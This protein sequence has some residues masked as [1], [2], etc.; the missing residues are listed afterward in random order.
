MAL[1]ATPADALHEIV[2]ERT[3]RSKTFALPDGKKLIHAR[4]GRI[5]YQDDDGKLKDIDTTVGLDE[6]AGEMVADKLPYKFRL[7]RKG[8]GFTYQSRAGGKVAIE[9]EA[10]GGQ[11]FD[12]K[13]F[14]EA[15]RRGNR[16]TFSDVAADL[17]IVVAIDPTGVRT[18]RVL[19][20]VNAPKTWRWRIEGDDEGKAKLRPRINGFDGE[21]RRCAGLTVEDTGDLRAESWDGT[22]VVRLDPS[23]RIPSLSEDVSYPVTI[24]PDVT[25]TI[26]DTTQDGYEYG[27]VFWLYGSSRIGATGGGSQL[28]PGWRFTSVA[29]DQGQAISEAILTVDV[30]VNLGYGGPGTIYG[31]DTDDAAAWSPFALTVSPTSIAK[32]SASSA[33]TTFTAEGL[34]SF[35]VTDVVQEIIDR[36]GWSNGND[37]SLFAISASSPGTNTILRDFADGGTP[38]VLEITFDAGGGGTTPKGPLNNPFSGPF[39]GPV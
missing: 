34:R 37:L 3:A 17:D 27:G 13:A 19:K 36:A 9:L 2:E 35:D 14:Y 12:G 4:L 10:V 1:V 32:T 7:H 8:I 23:T 25:E 21:H 5:H 26:A 20:S 24:D 6:Q 29:V 38:A 16:I 33:I 31:Y 30:R 11:P 18:L 22:V 39:G 15:T 28:H